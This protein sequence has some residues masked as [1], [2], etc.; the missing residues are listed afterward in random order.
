MTAQN[1]SQKVAVVTGGA[2]G[3]GWA[4]TKA[5]AQNGYIVYACTYSAE[6]LQ[7]AQTALEV[8]AAITASSASANTP[9]QAIHLCRCDVTLCAEVKAWIDEIYAREKRIDVLVNNANYLEWESVQATG[10]PGIVRP[11]EVGYHGMVYTTKAVLPIMTGQEGGGHIINL[12]SG[13]GEIMVGAT[14]ASY[15][16]TKA[17]IN[18]FSQE[19]ALETRAMGKNIKVTLFRPGLVVGTNFLGKDRKGVSWVPR[20]SDFIPALTPEKVAS[21]VIQVI[22]N[23]YR[24]VVDMPGILPVLYLLY[25]LAPGLTVGLMKLGGKTKGAF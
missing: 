4:I 22:H 15:S 11:M 16:A 14:P 12:G 19:L 18:A 7:A 24:P 1:P 5:L 2:Q 17:A 23:K 10:I 13:A 6:T 20:L 25:H 8:Q 9:A 21:R 3:I